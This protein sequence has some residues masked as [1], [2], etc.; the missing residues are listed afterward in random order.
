MAERLICARTRHGR[1]AQGAGR[2]VGRRRARG[3][4]SLAGLQTSAA[5][6]VDAEGGGG[7][8]R[9]A[10]AHLSAEAKES[11]DSVA[12][13]TC[14]GAGRGLTFLPTPRDESSN[15]TPLTV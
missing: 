11:R 4:P 7:A 2:E 1:A 12:L 8:R 3:K 14:G 10:C 13:G 15:R 9:R 6:A 5:S